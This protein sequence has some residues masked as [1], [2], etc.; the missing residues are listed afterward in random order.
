MD[1]PDL[2]QSATD[3]WEEI[4]RQKSPKSGGQPSAILKQYLTGQTPG[5]ALE[6]GCAKGDDAV[7][8]AQNGW[9]VTAVDIS[10]TAL[11]YAEA[12]ARAQGMLNRIDFQQ[13]DL[14]VSFPDLTA[15]LATAMFL[16]TPL[17]F[18]RS[19]VLRQAADCLRPGGLLLI[20]SHG[21]RAPWSWAKDD[22]LY[23]TAR[24]SLHDLNL[25]AKDWKELFVGEKERMASGPDGQKALV[26]DAI[27]FLKRL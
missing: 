5:N 18:P 26:K 7:W 8:L 4:Y 23:P 11:D 24:Q 3:F 13:H 16:Q 12:N 17:E 21:S 22:K 1:M 27:I 20:V 25:Q 10:Q 19:E 15:D 14:A 6:L 2:N 9:K